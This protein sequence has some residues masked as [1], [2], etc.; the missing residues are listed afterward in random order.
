[1]E[2]KKILVE[3][4]RGNSYRKLL[5]EQGM[6]DGDNPDYVNN[7]KQDLAKNSIILINGFMQ[8]IIPAFIIGLIL[9][10]V[11]IYAMSK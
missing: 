2:H 6:K 8:M 3:E 11:V 4:N 1:M 5:V 7:L 10:F 9:L